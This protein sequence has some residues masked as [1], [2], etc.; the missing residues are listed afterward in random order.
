M[1]IGMLPTA[2]R[3]P[4]AAAPPSPSARKGAEA[5]DFGPALARREP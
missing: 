1:S 3:Q 2:P 5:N 4:P